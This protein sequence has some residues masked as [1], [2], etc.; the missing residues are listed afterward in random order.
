MSAKAILSASVS[1][2]PVY[3]EDVFSTFLYTGTGATQTITNGIDLSGKGGLVWTK[4]RGD[5]S[6][7][8][9]HF[10][11]DT[12]R[13][14]NGPNSRFLRSNSSDAESED[15]GFITS[16]SSTGYTVGNTNRTN[17][18]AESFCSWTF[19]EQPK[20]FDVV[21]YTGDGTSNRNI[22]HSLGSTPGCIIVKN[23]SSSVNWG[24]YHRSLADGLQLILN[25]D[26]ANGSFNIFGPNSAQTATTFQTGTSN[27]NFI[28]AS[29]ATYVAYLFAHDAGG[30]GTAGT[31][32][33]VS[34]GSYAGTGT[35][36]LTVNLGWEPQFVIVK[37]ATTSGYDWIIND[38][39]RG[40]PVA[41]TPDGQSNRTLTANTANAESTSGANIYP[42]A[43]GFVL[44]SA[45]NFGINKSS[46]T[47]IYI[48]IRRGPMKTPTVGTA[49][50]NAIARTGTGVGNVSVTGVGFSP[51]FA[52]Y[53]SRSGALGI[54]NDRLRGA[55]YLLPSSTQQA[56][57]STA[58]GYR[59]FLQDGAQLGSNTGADGGNESS[60]PYANW[61]FRRAPGFF[62]VVAYTG[63]GA[64]QQVTHNLG[65]IPE[66]M[67]IKNRSGSF[68]WAVYHAGMSTDLIE[69]QSNT[70]G[71][72]ANPNWWNNGAPTASVIKT[73]SSSNA[74]ANRSGDTFVAYLF[75]SC[76]GVSKVGSYTGNGTTQTIACGFTGG[77][78]FVLIR[79]KDTGGDWYV[80]DTARGIISGND[81]YLLLNSS[82]AEVTGTDYIDPLSS[83]FEI[84]STA[85][86]AINANGG[87]YIYLSVA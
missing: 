28:N 80:W 30:F 31:D 1:A 4:N 20:F 83:G 59:V 61:F 19:R 60:T 53:Q 66:M 41:T 71:S 21:T 26:G 49:V 68:G 84:S 15:G 58:Y 65:V 87:S 17:A 27:L 70:Y 43:N 86:A 74:A 37:N 38:T 14:N 81:P 12:V 9:G 51:D 79:R 24:V 2:A 78:R 3:V 5:G 76:P 73:P 10:F 56:T 69:L 45:D 44:N 85:P 39:M 54:L 6:A 75:A 18:S 77:A 32:N 48:A 64:N 35:A 16:T 36:G 11:W 8:L 57:V 52:L 23:T 72:S 33:V 55:E 25:L 7:G 63:T 13:G 46:N 47:F 67:I 62:D 82:A 29:G 22:P 34:C 50:Y 42:I 40:M